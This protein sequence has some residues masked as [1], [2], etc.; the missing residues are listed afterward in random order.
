MKPVL[1]K[2][3]A[4]KIAEQIKKGVYRSGERLPSIR[5]FAEKN[6]ISVSTA[7][8]VY[9]YL[10]DRR[11]ITAKPKSGYIVNPNTTLDVPESSDSSFK[12][13]RVKLSDLTFDIVEQSTASNID[14]NLGAALPNLEFP[15]I[16]E[17]H[18]I[19]AKTARKSTLKKSFYL[20]G[21]T[22][23][24]PLRRHIAKRSIDAGSIVSPNQ[25]IITNGCQEAIRLSLQAIAKTGDTIL[26]ES[27]CFYGT[28][29][30]IELLGMKVLEVP[31]SPQTGLHLDALEF[32]FEKWRIAAC[33][34]TP[35]F[36]NPL[37]YSMSEENKK[38]LLRIAA[39][40][41]VPIIE[42]DI[43]GELSYETSRPRTIHS[44][45][46]KGLVILCSSFSKNL[47]PGIRLG[48]VVSGKFKLRIKE[49]KLV[50][51]LASPAIVQMSM[52]EFLEKGTFD[53]HLRRARTY[54]LQQKLLVTDLLQYYFS[55]D[56]KVTNPNGGTII[57]VELP[58]KINAIK[59]YKKATKNNIS[60]APGQLF[61]TT[62]KYN[63]FIRINFGY[64]S[65]EKLE[66]G[67]SLISQL[68]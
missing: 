34:L 2:T 38:R 45:D 66:K 44:Y 61:S 18:K 37:G 46:K 24:E 15:A 21:P 41:D 47:D 30:T 57:W 16:Y 63:N 58:D 22:G 52:A 54:Y 55:N 27:P 12:P 62:D 56:I 64:A 1:Y 49:Q 20:G 53:R 4:E 5:R 13:T 26:T 36:H 25:I 40:H 42:D 67:I 65:R 39:K 48:W 14:I 3:L 17:L 31:T 35:N 59:L 60:F 51:N 19:I 28:L 50:S 32:A 11:L 68:I 33:V 43:Y 8:N 23:Y 6:K 9:S 29:Q 10:E 7:V